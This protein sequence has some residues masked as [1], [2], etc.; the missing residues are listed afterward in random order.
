MRAFWHKRPSAIV[1]GVHPSDVDKSSARAPDGSC[2]RDGRRTGQ[3]G[4]PKY[5]NRMKMLTIGERHP[6]LGLDYGLAVLA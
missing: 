3:L 6:A 4:T 2:C 5:P 1:G